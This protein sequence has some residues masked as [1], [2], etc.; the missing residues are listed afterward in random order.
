MEGLVDESF[1]HCYYLAEMRSSKMGLSATLKSF[2]SR[3]LRWFVPGIGIKRWILLILFG[4]TLLAVGLAVLI[5]DIYRTAPS[6]WWLPAFSFLSLRFLDRTLRAIV[7]GGLGIAFLF[8]GVTGLNRSL[9]KPFLPSGTVVVDS[10]SSYRKRERGPKIVTIGGGN[11]LS[12]LLR[13]MKTQTSNLTAIVTV[14][15][16]G[17]SSGAI[18]KNM[19]ILPPGDIR[20]CLAALSDDEALLSQ[21]FQYRFGEKMGLNGHSLGNLLITALTDITGSFE[22]AVAESG[23]VLAV[24]GRVLPSTLHDVRLVA[25]MEN[26]DKNGET[27]V[28]GESKIPL[29]KGTIHRIWLE[30]D[31]PSGYPPAI[32]A[33]LSADLILV[34][35]GSL[36]TSIL[37]NLL[38]PDIKAALLSSRALKFY[39]CNVATQVGE[40]DKFTC[41]K[42]IQVLQ[43]HLGSNIFDLMVINNCF[44]GKLSHGVQWV[45]FESDLEQDF[46]V[47][48]TDLVDTEHPW[49]HDS[50]KLT[51]A[52]MDLYLEKTGPLVAKDV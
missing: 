52:I 50:L 32:Q 25:D 12:T 33:I 36:Y 26:K 34:G 24:R 51:S 7:F 42:H 21:V 10:I 9:L 48:A 38:V 30:P 16:D 20:N 2:F 29:A 47:Y 41:K 23:R 39:I 44:D 43:D 28:R 22:E 19:G 18:R 35:P 15:D 17:G 14:A 40:T 31:N 6:T 27:Q 4:T 46:Q 8:W 37:P 3:Q 11:G 45:K 5:L 49:R 13:G 1:I